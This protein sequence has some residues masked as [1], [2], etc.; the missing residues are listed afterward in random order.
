[1]RR[2]QPGHTELLLVLGQ[3]LGI[4]VSHRY[5]GSGSTAEPLEVASPAQQVEDRARNIKCLGLTP[6]F[7]SVVC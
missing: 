3:A 1:M 5:P 4:C 2:V 7:L 6:L